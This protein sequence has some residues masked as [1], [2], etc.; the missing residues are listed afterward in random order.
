MRSA[1]GRSLGAASVFSFL[2]LNDGSRICEKRFDERN[3]S[4]RLTGVRPDERRRYLFDAEARIVYK[5]SANCKE[6]W[7][8]L[9]G[10][11]VVGFDTSSTRVIGAGGTTVFALD[12]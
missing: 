8:Y 6:V 3:L 12:L 1:A 2:R 4:G 9:A 7:T 11:G 5:V 10:T